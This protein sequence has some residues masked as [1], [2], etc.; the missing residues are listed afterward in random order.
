[1]IRVALVEDSIESQNNVRCFLK[2]YGKEKNEV[3]DLLV[4]DSAEKF[5]NS[6]NKTYDLVLMDI[7]LPGMNGMEA[8]K[9]LRKLDQNVTLVFITNL[10]QFAIGGY[11]VG[12]IDFILKPITYSNFYLKF[13]RIMQKV[14]LNFGPELIVKCKQYS[15]RLSANRILYI[16]V[17]NHELIYHT[18]DGDIK[19]YGSLKDLVN[20]LKNYNFSLCN[21]S[22]L[23]NLAYVKEF[24]SAY[25]N[26][27]DTKLVI[28]RPKRKSFLND[29]ENYIKDR[30]IN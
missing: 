19:A 11:E 29:V 12:A 10:A 25:V 26:I 20:E 5:L 21:Q 18:L 22:Y 27:F 9:R 17:S 28:S 24:N 3:F 4:F 15:R 2:R 7:E 30:K 6:L 8:S 1:M 23:V 13:N 14:Y 16:E